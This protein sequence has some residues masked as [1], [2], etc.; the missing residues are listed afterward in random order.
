[1]QER[2]AA[3]LMIT[4]H[5]PHWPRPHPNLGPCRSRSLRRTYSSGVAGSISSVCDRPFTLSV[6]LLMDPCLL[7][8][9]YYRRA[10]SGSALI[11][12]NRQFRLAN[13]NS[14][15]A[16]RFAA[17]PLRFAENLLYGAVRS[18]SSFGGMRRHQ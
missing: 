2:T 13:D 15:R 6:S 8:R 5:A 1:M 14:M 10:T 7:V 3:P 12:A 16:E 11:L 18:G 17:R 9:A 4:V